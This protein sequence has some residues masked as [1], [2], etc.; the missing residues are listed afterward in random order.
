M[1]V[2]IGV[3][4]LVLLLGAQGVWA[5][6]CEWSA[7][8]TPHL[9]GPCILECFIKWFVSTSVDDFTSSVRD[10]IL[11]NPDPADVNSLISSYLDLLQPVF[12]LSIMII[13]F[14]L[15]FMS[16]SPVGR[17]KA[18]AMF[19]KLILTMILVTLST[20]IFVILL[21]ISKGITMKVLAGVTNSSLTM[22]FGEAVIFLFVKI[23]FLLVIHHRMI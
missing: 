1:F 17:T 20:E 12:V 16:G 3:I 8:Y 4:A 18:K 21:N 23:M 19:W 5:Q 22:G 7:W 2:I 11:I 6:I 10:M 9:W 15:V 14:Y 13:G